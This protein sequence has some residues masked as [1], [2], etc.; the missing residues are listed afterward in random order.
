MTSYPN[1]EHEAADK[2]AM[3]RSLAALSSIISEANDLHYRLSQDQ[4]VD[5]DDAQTINSKVRDLTGYLAELGTLRDVR[6][7]HAAD[8]ASSAQALWQ[9]Q[10]QPQPAKPGWRDHPEIERFGAGERDHG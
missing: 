9:P 3:R 10:P 2:A 6:E 8:Q 1:R 4:R 5:A 7:W